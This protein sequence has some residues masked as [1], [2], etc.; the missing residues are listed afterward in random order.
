MA[1]W[2]T[3]TSTVLLFGVINVIVSPGNDK[4]GVNAN[5]LTFVFCEGEYVILIGNWKGCPV[6]LFILASDKG[7]IVGDGDVE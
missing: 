3:K 4:L 2:H 6:I 5:S 1:Y 7:D